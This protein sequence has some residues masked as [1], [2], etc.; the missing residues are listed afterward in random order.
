MESIISV[1]NLSKSY[2]EKLVL[3]QINL[4]IAPGQVIGYIGPNGAGKSTTVKILI[5]RGVHQRN[6]HS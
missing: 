1:R 6:G 2:G 4:E 5:R 3:N